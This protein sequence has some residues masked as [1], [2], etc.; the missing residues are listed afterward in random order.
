MF[1]SRYFSLKSLLIGIKEISQSK[2]GHI[3]HVGEALKSSGQVNLKSVPS[4]EHWTRFFRRSV[5]KATLESQMSI[6]RQ[7]VTKT[8]QPLRI[9]PI[10]Q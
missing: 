1:T 6:C 8:P 9:A 7:S 4:F 5:A 10:D 2:L 3:V